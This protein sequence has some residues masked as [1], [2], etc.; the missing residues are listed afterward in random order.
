MDIFTNRVFDILD[1]IYV[2][3]IPLILYFILRTEKNARRR[4]DFIATELGQ[5]NELLSKLNDKK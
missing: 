3:S 4:L 2:V 5:T 1:L